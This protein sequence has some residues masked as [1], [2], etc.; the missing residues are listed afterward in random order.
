MNLL[1]VEPTRRSDYQLILAYLLKSD[2]FIATYTQTIRRLL[3]QFTSASYTVDHF[4]VRLPLRTYASRPKHTRVPSSTSAHQPF[5]KSLIA[6]RGLDRTRLL[7]RESFNRQK[8][9]VALGRR[10]VRMLWVR[11]HILNAL[12]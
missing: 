5:K 12:G 4:L 11:L 1:Y 2:P 7:F 10:L 6:K 3:M 8:E 9:V